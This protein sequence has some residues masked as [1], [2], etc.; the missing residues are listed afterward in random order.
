MRMKLENSPDLAA[1]MQA[2][3]AAGEKAVTTAMRGAGAGL[4][5]AWRGQITGAD[6]GTR[7][8]NS[9]RLATYRRAAKA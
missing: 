7:L 2:E 3:I 1:L 4:K 9:I 6:L 5:S 8:G